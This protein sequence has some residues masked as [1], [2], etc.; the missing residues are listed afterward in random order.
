MYVHVCASL[1]V[2]SDSLRPHGPHQSHS[3]IKAPPPVGFS[4]QEYWSRLPF[5]SPGDLPHPGIEPTS[6]T[7]QADS[8]LSEPPVVQPPQNQFCEIHKIIV[9]TEL[10]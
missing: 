5:L 3:S 4:R 1:S 8:L 10:V 6:P 9:F 2:L 7:L